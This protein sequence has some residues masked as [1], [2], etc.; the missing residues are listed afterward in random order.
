MPI[1]ILNNKH[2]ISA[3]TLLHTGS[4]DFECKNQR[5]HEVWILTCHVDLKL[6]ESFVSDLRKSLKVT[7]VYLAF[8]SA[9]TY[10]DGPANTQQ[11]L[12][13]IT[14]ELKKLGIHF[15]WRAFKSSLSVHSNGY[16]IVQRTN[17]IITDGIVLTASANFTKAGFTGGNIE[18]GYSSTTKKDLKQFVKC[19]NYLWEALGSDID[20][21]AYAG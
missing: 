8:N 3:Q 21:A 1:H 9:E 13:E 4:S 10:N 14:A 5:R 15:E 20:T 19:Y 7:D 6:I 11:N 2:G 18:I 16:A 12:Q 17:G